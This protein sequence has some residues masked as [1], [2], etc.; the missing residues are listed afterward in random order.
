MSESL[1]SF[2][3]YLGSYPSHPLLNFVSLFESAISKLISEIAV[4]IKDKNGDVALDLVPKGDAGAELRA[5]IRKA[6]AEASVSKDDVANS[7]F[8][9]TLSCLLSR[10]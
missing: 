7:E 4:S 10:F 3:T 9:F 5:L 1:Y 8:S 6:Q 2:S